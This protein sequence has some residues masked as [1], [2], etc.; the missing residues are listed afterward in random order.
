VGRV[1]VTS[2]TLGNSLYDNT[3]TESD[4]DDDD[5]DDRDVNK[6]GDVNGS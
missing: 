3:G 2:I 4:D 5:D 1:Q 6:C